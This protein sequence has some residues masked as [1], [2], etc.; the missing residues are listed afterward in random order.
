MFG[1]LW[2]VEEAKEKLDAWK[3]AYP[4]V[5][6]WQRR[7][8]NNEELEVRTK[9]GRRRILMP[10]KKGES[11]FTTNLN[12]PI[13]GL[14]ADCL[15]AALA[16]LWE[17]HL[18]DDPEIKLIACIHDEIILEAPKEREDYVKRILKECMEDAA[19]LVGIVSVPI[20][21]EPSAGPDWSAK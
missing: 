10:C 17:Q 1:I 7:Q 15:K 12:S 11:N 5:V 13:Q 8:G 6:D 18:C 21:A 2:T 16:L 3:Q 9:F 20:V 19:P 4:G 14:G